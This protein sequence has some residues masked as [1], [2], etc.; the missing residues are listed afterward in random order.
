MKKLAPIAV[1][2]CLFAADPWQS[3]PYTEWSDKEVQKV[4][5]N[6]PWAHGVSIGGGPMMSNDG[7]RR[8]DVGNP[9]AANPN[10]ANP[11][12][13]PSVMMPGGQEGGRDRIGDSIPSGSETPSTNL[14]VL[15][16]SA[17]PVKQALVRRRFGAEGATSSDAKKFLDENTNYL[18]GVSGLTPV[19]TRAAQAKSEILQ[20]T[21][22]SAKGKE[23]LHPIDILV[24]PAGKVTEAVFVF[25]K[26]TVFTIE[27]KDVEF[28]TELGG[29]AVKNKFRLKDMVI[30]GGLQL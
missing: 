20:R 30:A 21:T 24:S 14:V 17:L 18:I 1:A 6:S 15:W 27:D 9:N 3:K 28:S 8:S 7:P 23:P 16:Q 13:G 4:L 19:L 11:A 22:L 5:T 25:P 10:A 26:T 12:T 29:V 2:F